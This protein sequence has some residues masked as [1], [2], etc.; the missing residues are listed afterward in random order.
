[1]L[2]VEE[3][4]TGESVEVPQSL[5]ISKKAGNLSTEIDDQEKVGFEQVRLWNGLLV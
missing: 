3:I 5:D 1:M 4:L 2:T